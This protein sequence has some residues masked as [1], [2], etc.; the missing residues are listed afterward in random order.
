MTAPTSTRLRE[1]DALR[2]QDLSSCLQMGEPDD[3]FPITKSRIELTNPLNQQALRI[4][5][6]VCPVRLECELETMELH[7]RHRLVDEIRG[8]WWFDSRG[9]AHA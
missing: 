8:G 1:R 3:W 6:T 5:R 9:E 4:C 2:W 7:K